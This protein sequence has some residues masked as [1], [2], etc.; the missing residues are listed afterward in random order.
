MQD[1]WVKSGGY[2]TGVGNRERGENKI[3]TRGVDEGI[4]LKD[5]RGR[6][7]R[8]GKYA[9]KNTFRPKKMGKGE[10]EGVTSKRKIFFLGV[11]IERL[12]SNC[13]LQ[14]KE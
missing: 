1:I 3:W 7:E 12:I 6:K 13:A 2:V 8:K 5:I 11:G 9:R 4:E 14:C 10:E